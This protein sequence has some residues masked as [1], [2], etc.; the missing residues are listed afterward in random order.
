MYTTPSRVTL[1]Y[2]EHR[3]ANG[4]NGLRMDSTITSGSHGGARDYYDM[5][6]EM[7]R[8]RQAAG[9]A[10]K[11]SCD[12]ST[13]EPSS[14]F[15]PKLTN[16]L[17][18]VINGDYYDYNEIPAPGT[19]LSPPAVPAG[20]ENTASVNRNKPRSIVVTSSN[21]ATTNAAARND[22]YLCTD[23]TNYVIQRLQHA[24]PN[25]STVRN[26]SSVV[27]PSTIRNVSSLATPST[28]SVSDSSG[29][30]SVSSQ[31][32]AFAHGERQERQHK[33]VTSS[34]QQSK[35]VT[36]SASLPS[37]PKAEMRS[38]SSY[39]T[40]PPTFLSMSST[41]SS[42]TSS[43][44]PEKQRAHRLHRPSATIRPND[45]SAYQGPVD[46]D[47]EIDYA[48]VKL[49]DE[50]GRGGHGVF[51]SPRT[52][53]RNDD[54]LR[55]TRLKSMGREASM[56]SAR[57]LSF[58]VSSL[59]VLPE[60]PAPVDLD[61][62]IVASSSSEHSAKSSSWDYSN[63]APSPTK[64]TVRLSTPPA[65]PQ[66]RSASELEF[67]DNSPVSSYL[68]WTDDED[69]E[70]R[71][72]VRTDEE[73]GT[74]PLD[75]LEVRSE[76]SESD[77]NQE[78]D[79]SSFPEAQS[80]LVN[81]Q[82]QSM[83]DISTIQGSVGD[84]DGERDFAEFYRNQEASRVVP[85]TASALKTHLTRTSDETAPPPCSIK[86]Y[87][88]WKAKRE[89][90]R[91]IHAKIKAEQQVQLDFY[92]QRRMQQAY[93]V[94]QP[95]PPPPPTVQKPWRLSTPEKVR[96][97]QL[98]GR[99]TPSSDK[100]NREKEEKS[101][102]QK[103]KQHEPRVTVPL[104]TFIEVVSTP[105]TEDVANLSLA[106]LNL[107]GD[108]TRLGGCQDDL[109]TSSFRAFHKPSTQQRAQAFL[110]QEREKEIQAR[111][112]QE[113]QARKERRRLEV[114]RERELTRQR[115]RGSQRSSQHNEAETPQP[116][117]QDDL[118]DDYS[119]RDLSVQFQGM[120]DRSIS[121]SN[122]YFLNGDDAQSQ[123]M[124]CTST[125]KPSSTSDLSSVNSR[126][127]PCVQCK[128]GERT[129]IAMPCM[130]FAFCEECVEKM[131]QNH[132]KHHVCPV[133]QTKDVVFTK[134]HL[135]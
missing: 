110:R 67:A 135:G 29:S 84:V 102:T 70:Q 128:S 2:W 99:R 48:A 82:F 103:E 111:A 18:Q 86:G 94:P 63:A 93:S 95:P 50:L 11:P 9:L 53:E 121:R 22:S 20:K 34:R 32:S 79:E 62:S 71:G 88:A 31:Q 19:I 44:R 43:A 56:R 65:S 127:T 74:T 58:D 36:K 108:F 37:T 77:H 76:F 129:H 66:P 125:T 96:G 106:P 52:F 15:V 107:L 4:R 97:W 112:A 130:H 5:H 33:Q 134:V 21:P 54:S 69:N 40:D 27:T 118:E 57:K 83:E 72:S 120:V 59:P 14:S 87:E 16:S 60:E 13:I 45:P 24:I 122:A 115:L 92:N 117:D 90:E 12:D 109:T 98:F 81:K 105:A 85:L 39:Y 124:T 89:E 100:K 7:K 64:Q 38:F 49:P 42:T 80:P 1:D 113:R 51:A 126:L 132:R 133:C 119:D 73:E 3:G 30:T 10:P 8:A 114:L 41:D 28:K 55:A 78:Q 23:S 91:K 6:A 116:Q 46:L 68:I 101:K 131:Y 25:P 17:G 26:S 61:V 35:P 104:G 123:D 47:E 75:L